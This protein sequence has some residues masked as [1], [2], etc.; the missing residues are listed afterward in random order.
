MVYVRFFL[1]TEQFDAIFYATISALRG[2]SSDF[3]Q[4]ANMATA[5]MRDFVVKVAA[6]GSSATTRATS[7]MSCCKSI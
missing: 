4:L 3:L 6:S 1:A 7:G 2:L 5:A